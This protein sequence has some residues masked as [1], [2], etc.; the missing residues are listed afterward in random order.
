[1]K[2]NG[3]VKRRN[4]WSQ[5]ITPDSD[6]YALQANGIYNVI[7]LQGDFQTHLGEVK[8]GNYGLLLELFISPEADST[9]R[10]R[11]FVTFDSSEMLGNPYSFVIDSRQAKQI[12]IA[13]TDGI[14]TEVILSIYQGETYDVK[15]E[16]FTTEDN[17]FLNYQDIKIPETPINFKN[18]VIGFGSDLTQV[19]NHAL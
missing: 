14:I 9:K 15:D 3:S 7:T 12:A 4:I 2:A 8:S 1:L 13:S 10:I 5:K 16:A 11:K 18:I 19:E 6:Y 17:P